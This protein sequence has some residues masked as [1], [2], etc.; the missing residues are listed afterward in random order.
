MSR[1]FSFPRF[2]FADIKS[3]ACRKNYTITALDISSQ[4]LLKNQMLYGSDVDL[5]NSGVV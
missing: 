5:F 1:G 3:I 4:T 2:V